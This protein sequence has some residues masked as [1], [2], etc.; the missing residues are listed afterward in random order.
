M[1]PPRD[2]KDRSYGNQKL[3]IQS[4]LIA[5]AG[6][7]CTP[8]VQGLL[9]AILLHTVV[10]VTTH[11]A[12]RYRSVLWLLIASHTVAAYVG[13]AV[14]MAVMAYSGYHAGWFWATLLSLYFLMNYSYRS[15]RGTLPP[16]A[17]V[18]S[19]ADL[20]GIWLSFGFSH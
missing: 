12:L 6:I 2:Q 13:C 16:D 5:A 4:F 18:L 3:D 19:I 15:S 14:I 11:A 20:T 10:F 9:L 7:F 1:S 17:A 8:L